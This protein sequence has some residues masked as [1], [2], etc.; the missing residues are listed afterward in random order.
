MQY[1]RADTIALYGRQRDPFAHPSDRPDALL[2]SPLSYSSKPGP[3]TSLV[4]TSSMRSSTGLSTLSSARLTTPARPG[5]GTIMAPPTTDRRDLTS[6]AISGSY[7][8]SSPNGLDLTH[9][10]GLAPT[11]LAPDSPGWLAMVRD[12][13]IVRRGM[14]RR[15]NGGSSDASGD[16]EGDD[17]DPPMLTGRE[18]KRTRV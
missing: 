2:S 7:L 12:T 8:L 10:L 16:G 1:D 11:A 18:A 6:P 17:D 15:R 9:K 14:K 13:P 3:A 4:Q 5:Y